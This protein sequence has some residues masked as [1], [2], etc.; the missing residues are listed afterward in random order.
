MCAHYNI[1]SLHFAE[2]LV[3]LYSYY[4][5]VR[6]VQYSWVRIFYL[7]LLMM[8]AVILGGINGKVMKE[9]FFRTELLHSWS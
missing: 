4:A 5:C 7:A 8:F 3:F 6:G 9:I 2:S 1:S